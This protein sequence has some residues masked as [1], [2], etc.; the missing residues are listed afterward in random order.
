MDRQRGQ[1][2]VEFM[3]MLPILLGIFFFVVEMSLYMT[4]IHYTNYATF[5]VARSKIVGYRGD[6]GPQTAAF[7]ADLLLTGSA[8]K[9][10]YTLSERSTGITVQLQSWK[11]TFPYLAGIMPDAK[12]ATS[13]NLGPD[14]R[15]YETRAFTGCADNDMNYNPC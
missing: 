4:A 5:T 14:E 7:V 9:D 15:V 6:G 10:N 1:S 3:L 13:V 11:T 8:L 2:T 12:F